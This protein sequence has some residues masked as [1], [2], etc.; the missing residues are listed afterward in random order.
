VDATIAGSRSGHTV[1]QL[2]WA[3]RSLDLTA[4]RRRAERARAVAAYAVRRLNERGWEAWRHDHAFT[5]VIKS[6]SPRM[7]ERWSLANEEGWSHIVC[8]PGVP[9]EVIDRFVDE[10]TAQSPD[11]DAEPTP[12]VSRR[13]WWRWLTGG[14]PVPTH[15]GQIGG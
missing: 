10:V 11:I 4:H 3:L 1:L 14:W 6:P 8:V 7:I 9:V 5:V 13:R 12:V 15:T 2:W